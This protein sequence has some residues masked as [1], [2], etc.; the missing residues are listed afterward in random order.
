MTV[1]PISA[2]PSS[3]SASASPI[4]DNA[5]LSS[6]FNQF[7]ELLTTQVQNQDPFQPLD[8]TQFVEQLATFSALEQQVQSNDLLKK[9]LTTLN[10]AGN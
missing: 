2:A 7:L 4:S 6:E 3:A 9:I 8:S 5:D 10:S 1:S